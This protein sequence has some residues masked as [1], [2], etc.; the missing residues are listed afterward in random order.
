MT[1]QMTGLE[2]VHAALN[3]ESLDRVPVSG[4]GWTIGAMSGGY[5][6]SEYAQDANKMAR[7]QIAFYEKTGVDLLHPTSDM[8][9]MAEGFGVKMLYKD[10]LTPMLDEF[11]V[12]EPEQ[13]EE[14]EV[15]DPY[16]D[17]RMMVSIE[18]VEII[19]DELGD[20][21]SIMP[22]APSPLT[23]ATHVRA[24]EN[25]MIDI[26]MYPDLLRKGLEVM[27]D[28]VID[29]M[30]A[31]I[32]AGADGILYA[33]TRA[34][35]EIVTQGQYEEFGFDYDKYVLDS[36]SLQNGM[37]I[38][39]VC[40]VEPLFQML[41]ELPN[42][43]GIN[44]WDMGSNLNMREAK[45]QFGENVCLVGGLDQ[46]DALLYGTI[47]EVREEARTSIK[48]GLGDDMTGMILAPGCEV[49][50]ENPLD[51]IRAAAEEAHHFKI[52]G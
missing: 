16:T 32:D 44:W 4:M 47:E 2:R 7:G 3:H 33:T 50:P 37:N 52:R 18:A 12:E 49:S 23:S 17:G 45:E 11:A 26:V 15:L 27:A 43:N 25:V 36:I 38:L 21:A 40:G 24:M 19:R 30:D 41:S 5:T 13:W 42:C 48:E 6:T 34:S 35:A 9:Q 39:H 20:S 51:K 22:Y 31:M 28:T 1:T 46:T 8:G 29:Y 10:G 14:L